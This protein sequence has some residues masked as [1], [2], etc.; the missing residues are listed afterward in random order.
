[1][2]PSYMGYV[3]FI[4]SVIAARSAIHFWKNVATLKEWPYS[5][6]ALSSFY[7]NGMCFVLILSVVQVIFCI[8]WQ[9]W[10]VLDIKWLVSKISKCNLFL[11]INNTWYCC[12]KTVQ[13]C[14]PIWWVIF[15]HTLLFRWV[16]V[17]CVLCKQGPNLL[18]RL[19]MKW[20][21]LIWKSNTHI[22][23]VIGRII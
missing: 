13:W 2:H 22:Y 7:K 19:I 4:C 1:M 15:R 9:F 18:F 10:G 21:I 12:F 11:N 16:M 23:C 3:Y 20:Y 14:F 5:I 6:C 17:A 8:V